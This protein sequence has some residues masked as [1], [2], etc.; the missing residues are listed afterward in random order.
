MN[1][2]FIIVKGVSNVVMRRLQKVCQVQDGAGVGLQFK[3]RL[4]VDVA[5]SFSGLA[6]SNAAPA[7]S[8]KWQ[9]HSSDIQ[10]YALY[11]EP[12]TF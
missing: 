3:V 4:W 11:I 12:Y 5:S 2:I 8:R 1:Q 6:M 10:L 7:G 9:L